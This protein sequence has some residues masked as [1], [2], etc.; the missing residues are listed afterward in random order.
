MLERVDLASEPL[1]KDAYKQEY[2]Q[3]I[4]KLVVLQQRAVNQGTGLVVLFEGWNGA[5]KAAA[6]LT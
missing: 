2:D 5:G 4:E 1:S 6:S 3:L